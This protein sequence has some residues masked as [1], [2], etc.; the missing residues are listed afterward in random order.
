[1]ATNP[2]TLLTKKI[3]SVLEGFGC[4]TCKYHASGFTPAGIP[5]LI[6]IRG[7]VTVWLE[8]KTPTGSLSKIQ[9]HRHMQM[10]RY[11]ALIATV[12]SPEAALEF[13]SEHCPK[14]T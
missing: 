7:G 14:N 9:E 4:F 13:V 10:R 1:M 11:G 3:V 2:E 8:I 12:R 6:V 5:D